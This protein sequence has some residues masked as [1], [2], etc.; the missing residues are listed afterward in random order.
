LKIRSRIFFHRTAAFTQTMYF[1]R[2]RRVGIRQ[3]AFWRNWRTPILS[4]LFLKIFGMSCLLLG[5][6]TPAAMI[7]SRW[8]YTI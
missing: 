8:P 4:R 1:F 7:L 5:T 2:I 6:Q 3:N